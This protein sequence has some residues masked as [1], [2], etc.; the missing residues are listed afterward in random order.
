[1]SGRREILWR[2]L[3]GLALGTAVGALTVV[4][5]TLV[6]EPR[7][8]GALDVVLVLALGF[9]LGAPAGVVF[10]IAAGTA[11]GGSGWGVEWALA[12]ALAALVAAAGLGH[13]EPRPLSILLLLLV[14][15]GPLAARITARLFGAAP[16]EGITGQTLAVCAGAAV[17]LTILY[18]ALMGAVLRFAE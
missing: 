16:P 17:A 7:P 12:G 6:W 14:P 4:I 2:A 18:L 5:I 10:A 15:S 3:V 9:V 13:L 8:A 11:E 1:M